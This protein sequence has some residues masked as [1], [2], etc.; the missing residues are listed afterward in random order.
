MT[1]YAVL[2]WIVYP[3][4]GLLMGLA[5]VA[6]AWWFPRPH[7]NGPSGADFQ[8]RFK[9]HREKVYVPILQEC[10]SLSAEINN[11][12]CTADPVIIKKLL[13]RKEYFEKRSRIYKLG[14]YI[15]SGQD[16]ILSMDGEV[17]KHHSRALK[18][19]FQGSHVDSHS[20]AIAKI[21]MN[22]LR[23]WE[24]G[25]TGE[26]GVLPSRR[27]A[28]G[29]EMYNSSPFPRGRDDSTPE[30]VP[31]NL[32]GGEDL[33]SAVQ[34]MLMDF[35]LLY[36]YNISPRSRDGVALA[37]ELYLYRNLMGET[38]A[39]NYLR[40]ARC[41]NRIRKLVN[42]LAQRGKEDRKNQDSMITDGEKQGTRPN[43]LTNLMDHGFD[44]KEISAEI[45]HIYGAYKAVGFVTTCMIWRLSKHPQWV[46]KLRE[47]WKSKL[48]CHGS[49]TPTRGDLTRLP[50]TT[51]VIHECLRMHVVSFGV[52]RQISSPL[53]IDGKTFPE[54]TE[55]MILLHAVHH[56]PDFWED[57]LTFNP[58]RFL[59]QAPTAYTYIPFLS[60]PR[61]CAGQYL[62]D[63]H[64]IVILHS[65]FWNYNISTGVDDL[66]LKPDNY[67]TID[68]KIP[69]TV[70]KL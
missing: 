58:S 47:E 33:F 63:L 37:S 51:A 28:F 41:T 12:V 1:V 13:N 68:G 36:G 5:A 16:G 10:G 32:K 49:A 6:I 44:M 46:E 25:E 29:S 22:H 55:V 15:L 54:G 26:M 62:A 56:H 50:L 42:E 7:L 34:G 65:I 66:A 39:L 2:T 24:C 23:Y 21:T 35:I 31:D 8:K 17:W 18:P 38:S 4:L 60:G 45:N 3:M 27:A 67:S 61:M 9:E 64:L 43:F 48:G 70:Q 40:L 20:E 19:L 53:E 11:M 69:F 14:R 59:E 30:S 57:P 52:V